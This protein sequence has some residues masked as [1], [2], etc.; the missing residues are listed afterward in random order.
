[1]EIL[2]LIENRQNTVGE[3]PA[4]TRV[5]L[6]T[7]PEP[8]PTPSDAH[9]ALSH[10]NPHPVD[11]QAITDPHVQDAHP[12]PIG[13]TYREGLNRPAVHRRRPGA[14]GA[15]READSVRRPD[16]A[17]YGKGDSHGREK[18]IRRTKQYTKTDW[19]TIKAEGQVIH[20]GIASLM[21]RRPSDPEVHE[22]I[23]PTPPADQRPLLHLLHRDLPSSGRR[24]CAGRALHRRLREDQ[25]RHGPVYAG[26][27]ARLLRQ[28][29][30]QI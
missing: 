19:D 29:W 16:T 23:R 14:A 10:R 13:R 11:L 25:T 5:P 18:S 1:M 17:R 20:Q 2:I 24:V 7:W 3:R 21:D 4:T 27:D 15:A 26:G 9:S 6:E 12:Q 22:W 30:R 8:K 28:A